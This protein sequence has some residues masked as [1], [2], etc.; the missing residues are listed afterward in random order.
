MDDPLIVTLGVVIGTVTCLA[1]LF[2]VAE[3]AAYIA[4]L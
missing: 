3:V 4:G 1:A 2:Q